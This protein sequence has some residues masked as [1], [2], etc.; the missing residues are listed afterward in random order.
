MNNKKGLTLL[1]VIVSLM[2]FTIVSVAFYSMFASVFINTFR[3]GDLT[4]KMFAAQSEVEDVILD[5]KT[6]LENN[7]SGDID[8]E[9]E[10][11]TIF[12]GAQQRTI[13]GFPIEYEDENLKVFS[14]VSRTRP[15]ELIVPIINKDVKVLAK[16]PGDVEF[17]NIGMSQLSLVV[18]R[19]NLSV[20]KPN[21]LSGDG[22][23]FQWYRSE[24]N[25]YTPSV[26]PT[27]VD[28]FDFLEAYNNMDNIPFINETYKNRIVQLKVTPVGEKG[29]IGQPVAS[30]PVLISGFSVNNNLLVHL[31]ASY[32]NHESTNEMSNVSTG[33]IKRWIDRGPASATY[34]NTS[35]ANVSPALVQDSIGDE[36]PRRIFYIQNNSTGNTQTL[37]TS[38]GSTT[39][40]SI[41]MYV[42]IR[43]D[44]SGGGVT[45]PASTTLFDS[46][47]SQTGSNYNKLLIKLSNNRLEFLRNG[48]NNLSVYDD[49]FRTGD[50]AIYKIESTQRKL[51]VSSS[52][53][54]DEGVYVFQN[55]DFSEL[56]SNQ[57]ANGNVSIQ[58]IQN[59]FPIGHS[60]GEIII[61]NSSGHTESD[62]N[63][64]LEYLYNKYITD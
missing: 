55:S 60:L 34:T 20:D 37:R 40:N 21:Y 61:F 29:Q 5:V 39:Y 17:P 42:A 62:S 2:I 47:V 58:N 30:N 12:S 52:L 11:I 16:N 24:E 19:A 35:N 8:I 43:F 13:K 22:Y 64:V 23:L 10:S 28:D 6:K 63:K 38:Y 4:E 54:F 49:D 26:T 45:F 1:E 57:N 18:D 7:Q 25:Q 15:P 41:T 46:N 3:T 59:Y 9:E 51:T 14:F 50:W 44:V 32:I 53:L 36:T 27:F 33:R 56:K 48:T 31:D